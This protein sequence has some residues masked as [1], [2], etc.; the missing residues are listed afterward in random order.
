VLNRSVKKDN[1]VRMAWRDVLC[2]LASAADPVS[3]VLFALF[4][5]AVLLS[6]G[7]H[8]NAVPGDTYDKYY[9]Y[10]WFSGWLL[11]VTASIGPVMHIAKESNQVPLG[12][13]IGVSIAH[14][15]LFV[16]ICALVLVRSGSENGLTAL[17]AATA[18]AMMAGVGWV[19]QH[20]SSARSSRRAHT[21]GVLMQ[22]RLSSEFQEQIK[23]RSQRYSTGVPV[24]KAD[25]PLVLKRG[26]K[27]ILAALSAEETAALATAR[28]DLRDKISYDYR[29][30]RIEIK[31]RH[32]AI[33]G[34]VYLLN[35]YEFICAGIKR[36]ELDEDLLFDTLSDIAV[37]LHNDTVHLRAHAT[38]LRA[39]AFEHFNDLVGNYW[40]NG[41]KRGV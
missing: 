29:D 14:I 10:F 20:Q 12:I 17:M 39:A 38:D 22:S 32:R 33:E 34:V 18:A 30:K 21:F 36:K 13:L 40:R 37:G 11:L 26:L 24:E 8:W 3:W 4:W 9:A 25:A 23:K 5:G 15:A 41:K 27:E 1:I 2:P 6:V 28:E 16:V 31:R 19:V 7:L 35:F